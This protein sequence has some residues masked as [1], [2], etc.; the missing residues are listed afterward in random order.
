[1]ANRKER[2][3][4]RKTSPLCDYEVMIATAIS[5]GWADNSMP[6]PSAIVHWL[7][8]LYERH[9]TIPNDKDLVQIARNSFGRFLLVANPAAK[10]ITIGPITV[11][12]STGIEKRAMEHGLQITTRYAALWRTPGRLNSTPGS[13]PNGI[14]AIA[15][16][17][18]GAGA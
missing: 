15:K 12:Q 11:E 13:K 14:G 3:R 6:S 2:R 8:D 5:D 18:S 10:T 17:R 7:N 16:H 9:S 4:A 1:M